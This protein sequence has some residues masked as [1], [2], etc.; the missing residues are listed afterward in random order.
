MSNKIIF[1]IGHSTHAS[2][3]FL[4]LLTQHDITCLIDIR[5]T[6]YSRMAPQFNKPAIRAFLKQHH[7]LYAHF[8]E[9]F[10]ARQTDPAL[11]DEAGKVDFGQVR[12]TDTFREGVARLQKG[13][14]MGYQITL[15]CSEGDPFD[16][17]RFAMVAY[18]L[19]KENMPVKHILPHGD[20]IDNQVLEAQLLEKYCKK[21]PQQSSFF[22][23]VTRETQI[24]LGYTLRNRDIAY[25]MSD[26][27]EEAETAFPTEDHD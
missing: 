6:P 1:T 10:G 16:C 4:S 13:L 20:L 11:L 8:E 17:H 22:E 19:V 18:Q 5:S 24:E 21:I 25:A 12:A 14:A 3:Y 26:S 15:M 23:T 27:A 2:E 7:I 9:A